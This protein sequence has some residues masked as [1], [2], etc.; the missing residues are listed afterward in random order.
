MECT[1]RTAPSQT[2]TE[3]ERRKLHSTVVQTKDPDSVTFG[4]SKVNRSKSCTHDCKGR[5]ILASSWPT[6]QMAL[7]SIYLFL[8]LD[9]H[10][11]FIVN[12][13][14]KWSKDQ[15]TPVIVP[16]FNYVTW[17]SWTR[18]K[19]QGSI[20]NTEKKNCDNYQQLLR[21][22]F[23]RY[24]LAY[25]YEIYGKFKVILCMYSALEHRCAKLRLEQCAQ[26]LTW[27]V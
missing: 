7:W 19:L 8:R 5:C 20:G 11:K 27:V 18:D 4:N 24:E 23:Y 21:K 14:P 12:L 10:L 16:Q 15:L 9:M 1:W 26:E 17:Y 6:T 3:Q 13:S 25:L 22:K 2:Y